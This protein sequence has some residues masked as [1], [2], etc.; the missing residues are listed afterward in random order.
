MAGQNRSSAVM[1]QRVEPHKSLDDFPTPPWA[2][3]PLVEHVLIPH[4]ASRTALAGMSCWEPACNRGF[5]ARALGETFGEVIGSDIFD[6]GWAG[7]RFTADFL[8][9]HSD[10]P[11]MPDWIIT[12]P[13]FRLAE[14]FIQ[15][16]IASA[17]HGVA[18]IVRSAFLEGAGRHSRLFSPLPPTLIAQHVERV[19]M[20]KGR[21]DPK[22]STATSYSWLVWVKGAFTT[23]PGFLWIPPCRKQLE[24][25]GDVQWEP[26]RLDET[27]APTA[28]GRR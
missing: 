10:Q 23:M 24:R 8:F 22:A 4:C 13:P 16:A 18:V 9:P 1:Q 2:G 7:Q 14:R 25:P 19:P 17:R 21:Y 26:R 15:R 12:N 5:L 6:Y 27:G 3:R 20:V 28:D 11:P